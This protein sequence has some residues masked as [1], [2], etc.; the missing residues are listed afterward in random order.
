MAAKTAEGIPWCAESQ[1]QLWAL[2]RALKKHGGA[3][4]QALWEPRLANTVLALA[5]NAVPLQHEGRTLWCTQPRDLET[6]EGNVRCFEE[7]DQCK[8]CDARDWD[9]VDAYPAQLRP[10]A[11]RCHKLWPCDRC[12]EKVCSRCSVQCDEC[13]CNFDRCLECAKTDLECGLCGLRIDYCWSCRSVY[14]VR[15]RQCDQRLSFCSG[16]YD[17]AP[18]NCGSCL[19]EGRKRKHVS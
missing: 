17:R 12:W 19:E 8:T 16:C 14:L 10:A 7:E 2:D 3:M 1:A 11:K 9:W 5:N 15:C 6:W 4:A 18:R 13:H